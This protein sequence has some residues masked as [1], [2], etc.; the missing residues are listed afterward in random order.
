V[1]NLKDKKKLTVFLVIS[2]LLIFLAISISAIS[3]P[4]L[5]ISSKPLGL[6]ALIQRELGGLIFFHRNIIENE[7]LKKE[8]GLLRY[9]I[10]DLNEASQEN[11]RLKNALSFKQKSQFKVILARVIA[12][13]ADN[14]STGLIIDKGSSSGIVKGMA[15][16]TYSGL[17]GRVAEVTSW[18]SKIMLLCDPNLGVSSLVQRSR[19]EGLVCGTLGNNLIMKYLPEDADIKLQDEVVT[20][21]LT[22]AYP[23]G[24]LIGTVVDIS[25]EFSGLS[26]YA[27]IKPAVNLSNIEEVLVVVP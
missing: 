2:S 19:Q 13:P 12:R 9:K 6:F 11:I 5:N 27:I 4:I 18:T 25:K 15:V 10:N 24:L 26:C 7:G 8:V 1:F 21:G 23:K 20:S 16:I 3:I 22:D 17:A 14:W